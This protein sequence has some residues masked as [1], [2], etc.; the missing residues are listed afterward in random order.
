MLLRCPHFM[1]GGCNVHKRVFG[2]GKCVL[3]MQVSLFQGGACNVHKWCL[4]EGN[5]TQV[6]S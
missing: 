3:F 5:V 1:K 6:Q 2:T 4:G